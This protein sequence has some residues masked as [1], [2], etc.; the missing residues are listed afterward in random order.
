MIVITTNTN[1]NNEN[2]GNKNTTVKNSNS[3]HK[4]TTKLAAILTN[5]TNS[6]IPK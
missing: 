2:N 4:G 6:V 1:I 3:G 5:K